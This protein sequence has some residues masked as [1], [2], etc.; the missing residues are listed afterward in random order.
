M[1]PSETSDLF[2][3]LDREIWIVTSAAGEHRG[4]L[5]AT[6]VTQASI[7][8]QSPRVLVAI[9]K[10][11]ATWQL[12]EA[13]GGFV[14]HLLT[15]DR[16]DLVERFGMHSSRDRDKFAGLAL[17]TTS[18]ALPR[19]QD[20]VGWLECEVEA[21]WDAGD[22]M[23]Y[24]AK[25]NAAQAISAGQPVMTTR[26]LGQSASPAMKTELRRQ[27]EADAAVDETAIAEWRQR[28]G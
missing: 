20:A 15:P 5:V 1:T 6:S 25:V 23:F 16:L 14:L 18:H 4:G 19:L 8:P 28:H 24:L 22:R 17:D 21:G 3:R 10:L 11:H 12:I 26:V 7:A 9:S 27:L 2:N 13:S